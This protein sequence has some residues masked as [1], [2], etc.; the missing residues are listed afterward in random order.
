L[1]HG[2]TTF[3]TQSVPAFFKMLWGGI[4]D[5]FKAVF[6]IHS[7]STVMAA[8]GG[9]L[10][11]GL[12]NGM[13]A[14]VAGL[15]SFL[16]A[17]VGQPIVHFFTRVIPDA[18][19]GMKARVLG[20]WRSQ[21]TG[22]QNI[23]GSLKRG[24]LEP[25]GGFFTRTIPGWAGSLRNRVV[26]RW[27]ALRDGARSAYNS[28][29]DR[30]FGPLGG[31]FTKT[32]PGWAG[33]LKSR[34]ADRWASLRDSLT[35]TYGSIKNRVLNP[36]GN[37]FTKTIPGWA[38]TMKGRVVGFFSSMRDGLGTA[39]SGIRSKTRSPVNWVLDHVW[40]HGL[41][42]VWDR[43]SGWI[44]I[45]NKL[46]RIKL[47]AAGGTTG[48]N[49]GV[50]NQPTAIVGEGNPSHPEFVIP[51]DPKYRARALNLWRAAGAHFYESGGILGTIGHAVSSAAGKAVSLG[52][53]ALGFLEDPVGK[54][55]KLL[56][57]PLELLKHLKD[58]PWQRMVARFPA[59]AV[60]GLVRAVKSVKDNLLSGVGLGPSG[61]SGGS[62]VK[63]WTGVVQAMLREVG[64]PLSL[65]DI[66]LRRM[67]QESGGNPNIVNRW[68]SN[69]LA[70]H[71]SV[72]LMQV[73]GPTFQHYAGKYRNVGPFMYGTSVNPA[74]NVYSS[75]KYALSAYG[76]LSSAYGRAGGYRLGTMGSAPGWHWVGEDGPELAKLPAG[77]KIR[78]A[79][80]SA[81]QGPAA[82]A[83]VH[84]TVENHGVIASRQQAEDWLV[85]SL[86]SLRV[87]RRLPKALGG[88]A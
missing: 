19:S 81:R 71:P 82:G 73:I 7:P 24:V 30:V 77:T 39:W 17:H 2:A 11:H 23:W 29:R 50:Y 83:V 69:W 86:E 75:M 1:W 25:L 14:G 66:T 74:A 4:V 85:G 12:L 6:G 27:Y 36:L 52:K 44:G 56:K 47:L 49:A 59:M 64:Q 9:H 10:M 48:G 42:N 16:G 26:D 5:Y 46:G 8:L 53:G 31:F 65:T 13:L 58:A 18:A 38:Q 37:H 41:Y 45:K 22:L 70:G 33:S 78:S 40:N 32:I 3:F 88:S 63:R 35:G 72:G 60:T 76:S 87:K 21:V 62:G 84:L 43:I 68:D 79:R 80:S 15:V 55:T 34:V 67:N 51:T 20:L 57:A 28:M 61:G 54:A